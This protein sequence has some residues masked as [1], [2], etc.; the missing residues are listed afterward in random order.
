MYNSGPHIVDIAIIGAG[1]TGCFVANQLTAA[2]RDVL[3]IEKSRGLGGRCSRRQTSGGYSVDLGTPGFVCKSQQIR[4]ALAPLLKSGDLLEWHYEHA[5]F[6][7]PHDSHKG[8]AF[9]SSP[10]MNQLHR[11]LMSSTPRLLDT[12]IARADYDQGWLLRE[13]NGD[14]CAKAQQL[15]VTVPAPQALSLTSWPTNWY[16]RIT[17]AARHSVPQWVAAIELINGRVYNRGERAAVFK[18]THPLLHQAVC[19]SAKPLKRSD[20]EIWV[21]QAN[22]RWSA[23]H[24]SSSAGDIGT[25]LADTFLSSVN[26]VTNFRLLTTHFWKLARHERSALSP[27][28]PFSASLWSSERELG[29]AADWMLEGD[30]ESAL[31]SAQSI[32]KQVMTEH[33]ARSQIAAKSSANQSIGGTRYEQ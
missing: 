30:V 31:L 25:A 21:I 14:L 2:G 16:S 23:E 33:F 22:S 32:V 11:S 19:D 28:D 8:H 5:D 27:V 1:I 6:S 24:S 7:H 10:N 9:C 29:L 18:G 3:V 15:I 20:R 12:Q 17:R 13:A 26:Q 4:Q